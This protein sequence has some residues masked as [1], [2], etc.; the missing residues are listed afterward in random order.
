MWIARTNGHG[1]ANDRGA[2]L[3]EQ[4]VAIEAGWM[5]CLYPMQPFF[6][7]RSSDGGREDA[8]GDK[9]P[10]ATGG[11]SLLG[12]T[13]C[14]RCEGRRERC[15]SP[16]SRDWLRRRNQRRVREGREGGAAG[17]YLP[18][19]THAPRPGNLRDGGGTLRRR[20]A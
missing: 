9:R 20:A 10:I 12:G 7:S 11:H 18:A 19:R 13:A 3:S 15:D 2:S 5:T 16:D 8:E 4:R 6:G 17:D 1:T 14:H